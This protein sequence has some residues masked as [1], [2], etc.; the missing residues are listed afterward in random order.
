MITVDESN[1]S[2]LAMLAAILNWDKRLATHVH[3]M[4]ASPAEATG[5]VNHWVL[6]DQVLKSLNPYGA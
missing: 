2:A 6:M 1:S 5:H 4:L 3:E